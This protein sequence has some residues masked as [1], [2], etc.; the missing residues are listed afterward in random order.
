MLSRLLLTVSNSETVTTQVSCPL[1]PLEDHMLP[2][3]ND[4]QEP[5]EWSAG[6]HAMLTGL[7][8]RSGRDFLSLT[9][10]WEQE[11]EPRRCH[12]SWLTRNSVRRVW[13]LTNNAESLWSIIPMSRAEHS[14]IPVWTHQNITT[15]YCPYLAPYARIFKTTKY[16]HLDWD[17]YRFKTQYWIATAPIHAI[18]L[19]WS[20]QTDN[21]LRGSNFVN[22]K[23]MSS[24]GGNVV[25]WR[26]NNLLLDPVTHR[27]WG[28]VLFLFISQIISH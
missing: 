26:G 11:N 2:R 3:A 10:S 18:V 13:H 16:L 24:E 23:R 19:S 4:T 6:G 5:E 9:S 14:D 28:I 15:L 22:D 7:R 21:E 27:R 1:C 12:S 25:V 8:S 17:L 20:L